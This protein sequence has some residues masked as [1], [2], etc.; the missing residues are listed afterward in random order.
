ME[1]LTLLIT[2]GL[3]QLWGS[4]GLFQQD[5]WF[6][7]IVDFCSGQIASSPL[8][9]LISI[10][11]PC[12]VLLIIMWIV[13]SLLFGLISLLVYV[14]VLLFSLGRGEFND[15]IHRYLV[16][17]NDGDLEQAAEAGTEIAGEITDSNP[18]QK[19]G[20][21]NI[22][23]AQISLHERVRSIILYKGFERWF[24]VVFWFLVLGPVGALAYRLSYNSGRSL[25]L[26]EDD[27][28]Q[29][30]ELVQYLDWIPA[31]LLMLAFALTGNF[32]NGFNHCWQSM[33]H[34]QNI[35]EL[36][37][38]SALAAISGINE[39]RSYPDASDQIATYGNQEILA[40]QSLLTRSVI[41]WVVIIALLEVLG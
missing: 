25:I 8:R 26:N 19:E 27:R 3:L 36:L 10:G 9:L 34:N 18:D 33:W 40:I 24:A 37:D 11:L 2:L 38:V 41:C 23:G 7:E 12:S 14:S 17:W 4:G 30:L 15:A 31:R 6:D 21:D 28:K 16:F 32:V 39:N 20:A 22:Q 5:G 35:K 13:D 1:F 29:A